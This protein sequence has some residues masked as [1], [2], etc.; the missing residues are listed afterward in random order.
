MVEDRDAIIAA[1]K[2]VTLVYRAFHSVTDA[3]EALR[4]LISAG[5]DR[6][7]L[8]GAAFE[9]TK[10]FQTLAERSYEATKAS[11]EAIHAII[12]AMPRA[13]KLANYLSNAAELE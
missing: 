3:D 12:Q 4:S 13:S 9:R 10:Y 6:Q 7:S 1:N 2:L 8:Q 11:E 5:F